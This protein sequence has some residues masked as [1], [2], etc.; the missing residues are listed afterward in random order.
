MQWFPTTAGQLQPDNTGCLLLKV[1]L[2]NEIPQQFS[3]LWALWTWQWSWD[4]R[5]RRRVLL[6]NPCHESPHSPT[7]PSPIGHPIHTCS[8]HCETEVC[9]GLSYSPQAQGIGSN[10]GQKGKKRK[11]SRGGKKAVNIQAKAA[12]GWGRERQT[13]MRQEKSD[14]VSAKTCLFTVAVTTLILIEHLLPATTLPNA[15]HVLAF[16]YSFTNIWEA[17]SPPSWSWQDD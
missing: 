16:I 11:S 10:T 9:S 2:P 15:L 5:G 14:H 7:T 4:G 17:G 13:E 3:P 6:L 8:S 1:F 12:E